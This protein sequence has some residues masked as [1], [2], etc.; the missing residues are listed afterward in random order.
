MDKLAIKHRLVV[1]KTESGQLSSASRILTSL[2]SADFSVKVVDKLKDIHPLGPAVVCPAV[3]DGYVKL[4]VSSDAGKRPHSV[5][6]VVH[7]ADPQASPDQIKETLGASTVIKEAL[8]KS[9]ASLT[10]RALDGGF[11]PVVGPILTSA[12]LIPL[13]SG[14][15]RPIAVDEV[16]RR[17]FAKVIM[18]HQAAGIRDFFQPQQLGVGTPQGSESIV[19]AAANL[20]EMHGESDEWACMD[21]DCSNAFNKVPRQTLLDECAIH[22][23]QV[24]P[25][26]NFCFMSPPK[27]RVVG[28]AIIEAE[29]GTSEGDPCG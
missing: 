26:L 25:W 29:S 19:H 18:K 13:N 23:P 20:L 5:F 28:G 21:C 1:S 9:I 24:S 11:P 17:L 3:P 14:G 15:I 10:T 4:I 6:Q 22:F 27:L 2:G 12:N 8:R 7:P 16:W